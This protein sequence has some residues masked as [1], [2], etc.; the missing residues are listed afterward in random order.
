MPTSILSPAKSTVIRHLLP[1]LLCLLLTPGASAQTITGNPDAPAAVWLKS[2]SALVPPVQAALLQRSQAILLDNAVLAPAWA[3]YPGIEPA[4]AVYKGV[5]S[6]DSAYH[7]IGVSNWDVKLAH[8]QIELLF[9]RQLP[10]GM[11]PDVILE[12]GTALTSNTK[13]PVMTWAVAVVDHRAPDMAFLKEMYPKLA[14]LGEFFEKERGGDKDG[15]FYFAGGDAGWD[16]GWDDSIRWDNG[17]RKSTSDDHRLWAIDLNCYMVAHYDA[18]ACIAG[19]LDLPAEQATWQRKS[20]ALAKRINEKLWDEK[21]GFYIDRDRVTG[22]EGPAVTPAGFMPLFVHIATPE[23][24]AR[25]A[26][27]AADPAIFFPGLPS[28]AYDTPGFDPNGMWRGPAWVNVSWFALKGVHDYGCA[29]P[30]D[31]LKATLLTWIANDPSTIW[32]HYEPRTGKGQGALAYGW[33]AAF[34]IS[35]ILDW[36]NDHLT[37]LFPKILKGAS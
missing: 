3:P 2:V 5:W 26:R 22:Q 25:C 18:M 1:I 24:A 27:L 29:D 28:A 15:L 34:V 4:K 23:R 11:L 6:L 9:S 13:P 14:K 17:Y 16:A 12:D 30:A 20:D 7:A 32:E 31:K 19:R 8:Q 33:S 35:F 10:N 36:D 37:W 21:L